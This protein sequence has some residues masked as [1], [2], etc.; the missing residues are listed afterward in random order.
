MGKDKVKKKVKKSK[1][2]DGDKKKKIIKVIFLENKTLYF[3]FYCCFLL[4]FCYKNLK[5]Q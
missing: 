3:V 2:E 4:L 1:D 5:F